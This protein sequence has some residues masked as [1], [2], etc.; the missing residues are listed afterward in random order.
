MLHQGGSILTRRDLVRRS[1]ILTWKDPI[2]LVVAVDVTGST[3]VGS[4]Y[5]DDGESYSNENGEFVWRSLKL[6]KDGSNLVLRSRSATSTSTSTSIAAYDPENAW[7]K[8]ISDV[9][10]GPV[11]VLGLSREPLCVKLAGSSQGLEFEWSNGLAATSN[12]G[13]AGTGKVAS[14]LTI[15]DASAIV[16]QDWDLII[17]FETACIASP[18]IEQ[19]TGPFFCENK[20]HISATILRS[21]VNDG[22]CDEEC[23]D[24]SDETD[25]K[26]ECPNRCEVVGQ[27]YRKKTDEDSRKTRVGAAVRDG[28]ISFG[29]KEKKRLESEVETTTLQ[30]EKLEA[31]EQVLKKSL[32]LAETASADDIERKKDSQLFKQIVEM[33]E[34]IKA[35]RVQRFNLEAQ[36]TDLSSIL[37][38][39]SVRSSSLTLGNGT[40][41]S[42]ARFQSELSRYGSAW[43]ISS[44]QG[45]ASC[46]WS[47]CGSSRIR[48]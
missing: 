18:V 27:E 13:K 43:S 21:R 37:G 2:T 29:I 48:C 25:G 11:I 47:C 4:L 14:K 7:A 44:F 20:G 32:E 8:K 36:V 10:I 33:Q 40:D 6:E 3:A 1:A 38:D 5:L 34:A 30:V 28:Y 19:A 26:V 24:G 17:D 22:I 35:L 23:C 12:R 42:V 45:L 39:L 46:K 9:V 41:D 31:R 16:I 15:K